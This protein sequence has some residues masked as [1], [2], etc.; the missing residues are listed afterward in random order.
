M[1]LQEYKEWWI[2]RNQ[3][4]VLSLQWTCLLLMVCSCACQHL[5]VDVQEKLELEIGETASQL[6]ERY[7]NMAR[8]LGSAVPVDYYHMYNV[9]WLLHSTYWFKAEARFLECWHVLGAAAREAQE[10]GEKMIPVRG[11]C[12]CMSSFWTHD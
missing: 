9:Q 1:F 2:S 5:P 12:P 6:S 7:H 3:G 10:L 11:P 8:E 4:W